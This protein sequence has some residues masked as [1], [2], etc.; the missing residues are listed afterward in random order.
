VVHRVLQRLLAEGVSI[1]NLPAILEVLGDVG[2]ATRDAGLLAEHVRP[3]LADTICRPYLGPDGGLRALLLSPDAEQQLRAGLAEIGGE[4]S[5]APR[6]SQSLLD[7]I[8]RALESG[9]SFDSK[10]VL[11]CPA[12]LRRHVRRITERPLPHL[13]VLSYA[14]LSPHVNVQTLGTVELRHAPQMV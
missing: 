4:E 10:P 7:G 13:G 2:A 5:L 9:L 14:E 11:L 1:R 12:A 6:D 3:A 8:A